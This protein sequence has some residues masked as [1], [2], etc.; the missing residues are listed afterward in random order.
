MVREQQQFAYFLNLS[1]I[2]VARGVL[3]KAVSLFLFFFK[4]RY[5][6]VQISAD[7]SRDVHS[8]SQLVTALLLFICQNLRPSGGQLH[9]RRSAFSF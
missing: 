4:K 6:W 9:A 2:Q 3:D 8:R 1:L 7:C 5:E